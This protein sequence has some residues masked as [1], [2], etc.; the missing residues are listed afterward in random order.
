ML[1]ILLG[2]TLLA[3]ATMASMILV[4]TKTLNDKI[5]NLTLKIFCGAYCVAVIAVVWGFVIS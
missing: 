2:V 5:E 4:A 1:T 3:L